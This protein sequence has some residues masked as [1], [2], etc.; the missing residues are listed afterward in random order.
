MSY[1]VNVYSLRWFERARRKYLLRARQRG[2][3]PVGPAHAISGDPFSLFEKGVRSG[4]A[5]IL[6]IYPRVHTM[7]ALGLSAKDPFGDLRSPQRIFE[8]PQHTLGVRA[9]RPGDPQRSVH[10]KATARAGA[11]QVRQYE[12]TRSMS[13]VLCLNI[14]SFEQHWRGIWPELVEHLIEA[15]ASLANWGIESGYAVG[16]TANATLAQTDRTL[17]AQPSHGRDQLMHLL[18]MLASISYFITREFSEFILTESMRLP[19]GATLVVVTGF[20]NETIAGSLLQLRANG[21]R[22]VVIVVGPE[23]GLDLPGILVT[24]LPFAEAASDDPPIASLHGPDRHTSAEE[25]PA[26]T[27][28]ERFLRQKAANEAGTRPI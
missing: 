18:E 15:A 24:H 5:D 25:R 2:I 28:R 3:Y 6:I 1:L 16:I 17:I 26:E 14:A 12:P 13:V 11:L 22:L 9:Y 4:R 20:I 10:W 27:P 7:E 8:D 21:R 23:R 19:W